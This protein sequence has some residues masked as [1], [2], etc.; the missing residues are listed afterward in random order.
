MRGHAGPGPHALGDRT[1]R[2]AHQP[3]RCRDR[4]TDVAI[5]L[6]EVEAPPG[7]DGLLDLALHPDLLTG[8]GSDYVFAVHNHLNPSHAPDL[9]VVEEDRPSRPLF[10]KIIR[11]SFELAMGSLSGTMEF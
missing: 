1:H 10:T 7:R 9:S 3:D 2:R 5:T 4:Q 6:D 8:T 11:I